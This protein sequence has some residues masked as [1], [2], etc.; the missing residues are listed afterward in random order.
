MTEFEL[1]NA[2]W[3]VEDLDGNTVIRAWRVE[4]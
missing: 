3:W 1:V 4:E 2:E